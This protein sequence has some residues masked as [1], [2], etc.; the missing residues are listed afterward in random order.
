MTAIYFFIL[1]LSGCSGP[2]T[3]KME[4]VNIVRMDDKWVDFGIQQTGIGNVTDEGMVAQA[5]VEPT[6][7]LGMTVDEVKAVL[8]EPAKVITRKD[9]L[10]FIYY[11]RKVRYLGFCAPL[12]PI[13][14]EYFELI[15]KDDKLK[16]ILYKTTDT[17]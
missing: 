10:G 8:G 15:F 11:K 5:K 17:D 7:K 14:R 2:S 4:K 12:F 16:E 9:K 3:I 1:F 6:V 13:G